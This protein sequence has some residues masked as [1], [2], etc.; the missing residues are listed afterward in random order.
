MSRPTSK[1]AAENTFEQGFAI[2]EFNFTDRT[3][4]TE[5]CVIYERVAGRCAT[6]CGHSP[7]LEFIWHE[8]SVRSDSVGSYSRSA[9]Q[10]LHFRTIQW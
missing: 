9:A 6:L 7:L 10:R 8:A 4:H 3:L 2:S 1:V 5:R